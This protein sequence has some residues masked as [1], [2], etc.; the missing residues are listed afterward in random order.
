[1]PLRAQLVYLGEFTRAHT[2]KVLRG[3]ADPAPLIDINSAIIR[4]LRAPAPA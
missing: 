2:Q 4:G 3:E 1:V